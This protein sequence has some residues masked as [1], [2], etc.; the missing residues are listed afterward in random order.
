MTPVEERCAEAAP[1]WLRTLFRPLLT[2]S[3]RLEHFFVTMNFR[4]AIGDHIGTFIRVLY[5][6]HL[7]L[8]FG[9]PLEASTELS[10]LFAAGP[11]S[12]LAWAPYVIMRR[13]APRGLMRRTRGAP[14][15]LHLR[16][17]R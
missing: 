8:R 10:L 11:Y 1:Q 12:V 7:P 17:K 16:L 6:P 3:L 9:L 4:V 14:L 13:P 5:P 15:A 2:G